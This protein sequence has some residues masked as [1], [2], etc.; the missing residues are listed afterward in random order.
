MNPY[1]TTL[2]NADIFYKF[3][4]SQLEKVANICQEQKLNLAK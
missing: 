1:T 3:T 4:E 2:R